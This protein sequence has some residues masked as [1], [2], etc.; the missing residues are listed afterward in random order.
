MLTYSEIQTEIFMYK[1]MVE[2]MGDTLLISTVMDIY[3]DEDDIDDILYDHLQYR[4][5]LT[6]LERSK[7]VWY[8]V[9]Y[10]CEDCYNI[11]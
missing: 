1:M 11:N 4:D 7:L 6:E 10:N 8:Y 3:N 2:D 5:D 9:L